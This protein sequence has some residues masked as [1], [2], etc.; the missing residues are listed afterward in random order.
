MKTIYKK[1]AQYTQINNIMQ[2]LNVIDFHTYLRLDNEILQMLLETVGPEIQRSNTLMP[3]FNSTDSPESLLDREETMTGN[4]ISGDFR[5][6]YQFL[7]NE[8]NYL[9]LMNKA[10]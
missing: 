10:M 9:F 5:N 3:I 6:Y 1:R 4:V 8:E 2:D 7:D